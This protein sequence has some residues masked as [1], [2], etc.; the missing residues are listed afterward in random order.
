[1]SV[2]DIYTVSRLNQEVRGALEARFPPLWIEGELSNVA[3]PASGHVYFS[4]KDA[5]AQ[6]RCAM[7]RSRH[8]QTGFTPEPGMQVLVFARVSLFEPRGDFQLIV[9]RMEPAGSGLL[10]LE[11]D[12]LK[13][14]LDAEGLF[15]PARKR[16][17]PRWPTRIGVITSPS[18][19]AIRDVLAV[20]RRRCPMLPVIIYP[21]SVQGERAA[22]EL[23]AAMRTANRRAECDV[24]I[25]TRGGG[26][27]EDLWPFNDERLARA[28]FESDIPIVS[29]VGHEI[30][31]TIADLVADLRA[32]TPSASAELVSP[33]MPLLARHLRGLAERLHRAQRRRL[34]RLT[35]IVDWYERRLRQP[36]Q[37]LAQK[38]EALRHLARRLPIA[39]GTLLHRADARLAQARGRLVAQHPRAT[40]IAYQAKCAQL[41]IRLDHAL[42]RSLA[43]RAARLATLSRAIHAMSPLATLERGYA[44]VR[45]SETGAIARSANQFRAGDHVTALLGS[46]SLEL[47]VDTV[48]E[49]DA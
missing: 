46:G 26:S 12:R 41:R 38:H 9:E 29:G 28:I 40:L 15:D 45:D 20:L 11:F 14:K 17:I 1:M 31:F 47:T 24:L 6:V 18:G 21:S 34:E 36:A 4:L 27:L 8:T 32:P 30:D 7:F 25:L 39:I 44:I 42:A 43:E 19:A 3:R 16:P 13:R 22:E 5:A 23:V 10:Q 48:N 33:D 2:L 49:C 37:L 35:E